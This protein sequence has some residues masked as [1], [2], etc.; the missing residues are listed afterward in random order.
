MA[1]GDLDGDSDLDVFVGE[2]R[3]MSEGVD[4][5]ELQRSLV[6]MKARLVMQGESSGA[7]AGRALPSN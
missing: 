3:R 7:R 6:G 4:A 1:L 5:D 2:L